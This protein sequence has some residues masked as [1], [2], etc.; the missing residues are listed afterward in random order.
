[1]HKKSLT[2]LLFLI[3][4][5]NLFSQAPTGEGWTSKK[6]QEGINYYTYSGIDAI[7]GAPQ[8]VF[9][10]DWDTTNP[11][12]A[13]RFTWTEK[14]HVT[15]DIFR[16][17]NAVA[18]LNAAYE[19][20]SVVIRVGGQFYSQMPN[21]KVMKEPVPNWKSEGAVYVDNGGH[22]ISIAFDGKGKSIEEQREFYSNSSWDNI[23]TSAPMLI[24]D[25][26]PV[27]AFFVDS[28][29]TAAQ[30]AEYNYEDPT[31]HQGVRHPRTAVA[32]TADG[33]FLMVAVDGRKKGISEGMSARELT[34]F[35]ER[36]FHPR[37]ALNMDGGGS[38]TLC[39]RGEG[40]PTTHVVN[41]PTGNKKYD[42]AGERRLYT[43]FCIVEVP[44]DL[45]T[46]AR[47]AVR[48]NPAIAAG[49]ETPYDCSS[50][51]LSPAPKGYEPVYIGHY[52][53]HG[54][55]YAYTAKTYTVPMKVLRAAA[56][57]GNLTDRGLKLLG[58]LEAFWKDGQYKV[59]DLTRIGW[60]QHAWIAKEM[61]KSFP[62]AFKKGA[63]VDAAS[64]A[65]NR[66]MISMSAF[67]ASIAREVPDIDVYEHQSTL[68]I[69]ATRP[70]QGKNPFAYTGPETIFPY[71]ESS[72]EYF[73][74]KFPGYRTALG[75]IFK[76]PDTGLGKVDPHT[77][78]FYYY[79]LIGS[80]GNVPVSDRLDVSGLLTDEEYAILWE[81]DGYERLREYL[82]YRIT[83]S[84]VVDDIVA[85][86]DARIKE[87][88]RGADLRFGHDHVMMALLM[89][90]DV[91]GFGYLSPVAD[92]YMHSFQTYRSPKATN[93]QFV[94]YT[95]KRGK[96]GDVLVKL[97]FNGE[98]ARLGNL[99]PVEGPYYEW[100]SVRDYLKQRTDLF[101]NR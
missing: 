15:S 73:Y 11:S 31:R 52:G 98:E 60:D 1:M 7:S 3:G 93:L 5:I 89:I 67:C 4:T 46:D 8:Q 50:K 42:H 78:F 80:M 38:T 17:N 36:H 95:P 21:D 54:S 44:S 97:V 87:G 79:M 62:S 84:S 90:M 24:E 82:P 49:L 66:S 59:G 64:S 51:K 18:A 23:L 76:D 101:V 43:H 63:Y 69:Q 48:S 14:A 71:P 47:E 39:V 72:S 41:Y 68:D 20:E 12:Y 92:E 29:L 55:R 61:V 35:L 77:F 70:N 86:A 53:R 91:D 88:S 25:Y 37:Y 30:L 33:H 100:N 22:D 9:V 58:D 6:V 2:L 34:R 16:Q 13:L 57:S 75:R 56:D 40:D 27:G 65:S 26:E 96:S 81:T 74:R 83:C 28:T 85:K 94:F 10:I 45:R 32:L 99:K 19:P